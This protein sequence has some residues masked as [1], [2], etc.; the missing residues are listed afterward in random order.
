MLVVHD[1]RKPLAVQHPVYSF[2]LRL[3]DHVKVTII[4]VADVLLI[5]AGKSPHRPLGWF[6]FPHIPVRNQ[7]HSIWI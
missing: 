7:L 1:L 6:L 3:C 2:S 4:I 5:Q